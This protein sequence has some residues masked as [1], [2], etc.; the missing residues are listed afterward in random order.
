MNSLDSIS[1]SHLLPFE[2]PCVVMQQ[3]G[4]M[5]CG[6]QNHAEQ[7]DL[8]YDLDEVLGVLGAAA[9]QLPCAGLQGRRVGYDQHVVSY[10]ERKAKHDASAQRRRMSADN[11][12]SGGAR[13]TCVFAV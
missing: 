3:R 11:D 13:A 4:A 2:K 7:T 6:N 5:C 12:G 8:S 1:V 10:A 9:L